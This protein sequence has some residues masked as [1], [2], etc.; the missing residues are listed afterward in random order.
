MRVAIAVEGTRGD[1]HPM[2][3]LGQRLAARGHEVVLCATPDF[4]DV[5]EAQGF[6]FRPV[7]RSVRSFLTEKAS[8]MT[9]SRLAIVR[10]STRYMNDA[11]ERQFEALPT[12]TEGAD[13]VIGAGVQGGAPS[14]AEMHGVPYRYVVY[15]PAFL[16][17]REHAPFLFP[18]Q[19]FP[20]WTWRAL[21]WVVDRAQEILMRRDLNQLRSQMGLA[22]V[23]H[24]FT[25]LVS[26]RPVLAADR[27]LAP[28]PGDL[29][30]EVEQSLCLHPPDETPVPP[31][32]EA[33]LESGPPPVYIGF[34]SMT[35]P[36]PNETTRKIVDAV[37]RLG[38]RAI[39]SEGWAGLGQVALPDGI[40]VTGPVSHPQLFP[41]CAAVVHH[42]GAGT[43]TTAARAGTPQ[44]I[45]P[46]V[47]DQFYWADRVRLLG[48]GPADLPR[49]NLD[50]QGLVGL[51]GATLGNEILAERA[52]DFGARLREEAQAAPDPAEYFE[53]VV[54]GYPRLA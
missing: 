38:C 25:H 2:L 11:L 4:R 3:G 45:V 17:S 48:L 35:D 9:G 7:G 52:Q 6:E 20:R 32:L 29:P 44:I 33:F 26:E 42:G 43:T 41:R 19:R 13:L 49:R 34:G 18:V 10:E 46:H 31:K 37:G 24:A 53:A 50:V 8:A 54:T 22:P 15:C 39:L 36:D 5:V 23:P 16:P 14:A 1:V 28:P 40:H 30:I 21:W 47:M 12:A 51:L 27:S